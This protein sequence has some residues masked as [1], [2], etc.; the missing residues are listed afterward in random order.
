MQ[1]VIEQARPI[2]S[3][4][5]PLEESQPDTISVARSAIVY[6]VPSI[7]LWQTSKKS[8]RTSSRQHK[9][10]LERQ[11]NCFLHCQFSRSKA[12]KNVSQTPTHLHQ[13]KFLTQLELE[14]KFYQGVFLRGKIKLPN[15]I[16]PNSTE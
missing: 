7:R 10:Q 6:F 2:R 8:F 9:A 16:G 14:T 4:L 1:A 5:L 12:L 3:T 13:S 15:N 11:N